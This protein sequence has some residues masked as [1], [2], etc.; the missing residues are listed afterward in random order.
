MRLLAMNGLESATVLLFVFNLSFLLLLA[1]VHER[2][3][4]NNENA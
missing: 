3:L 2:P 1:L 4:R